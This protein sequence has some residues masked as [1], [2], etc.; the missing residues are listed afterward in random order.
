MAMQY[1]SNSLSDDYMVASPFSKS[2]LNISKKDL[3]QDDELVE[4]FL[5]SYDHKMS[6]GLVQP[7]G[8]LWNLIDSPNTP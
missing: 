8:N 5:H 1:K 2:H 7:L 3:T 6:N 4:P